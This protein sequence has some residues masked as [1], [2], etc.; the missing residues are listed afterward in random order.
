M[1]N[2]LLPSTLSSFIVTSRDTV[3]SLSPEPKSSP[4]ESAPINWL[5]VIM[6]TLTTAVS[7][8]LVP[9]YGV[10][11]GYDTSAWVA[12]VLITWMTGMAITGGYHR[13]WA[14]NAYDAHWLLRVWYALW[15]AMALQNSILWWSAGHRVHHRYVDDIDR[16]PYSA[17][18]GLWFSHIGWMLRRYESGQVS[19]DNV[20]N[21]M[22]DPV[23]MW[24][25]KYYF[26]IALGMNIAVPVLLG[27]MTGD[28][29]G[30]VLLAGFFAN[31][32]CS[33]YY[34]FY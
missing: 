18:K 25:H 32:C 27:I 15:G 23:V 14:H 2:Y 9:W 30:M 17:K 22:A 12:C 4:Q 24:Q 10:T 21:L 20:K 26:A 19:F 29:I 5:P 28:I 6:F 1:Y 33:S 3:M 7:L 8:I 31:C 34:F 16:D 13:L 11:C